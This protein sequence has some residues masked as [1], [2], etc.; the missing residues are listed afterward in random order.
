MQLRAPRARS[1]LTAALT[2]AAE[3]AASVR[4]GLGGRGRQGPAAAG[5]IT[6]TQLAL[7]Q[8]GLCWVGWAPAAAVFGI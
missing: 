3:N 6:A 4:L 8:V 2:V 5:G 7:L 1:Q